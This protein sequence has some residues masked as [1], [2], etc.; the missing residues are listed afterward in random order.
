MVARATNSIDSH[1]KKQYHIKGL[2]K[3]DRVRKVYGNQEVFKKIRM[4]LY[5]GY[6]VSG[7]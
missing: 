2:L 4:A 7:D 1:L 3:K 5:S 6:F